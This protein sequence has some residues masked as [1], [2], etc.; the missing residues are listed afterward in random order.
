MEQ[1][2]TAK[3]CQ[4]LWQADGAV[5]Q[6]KV[7]AHVAVALQGIGDQRERTGEHGCPGTTYQQERHNLHILVRTEGNEC[8]AQATEHQTDGIGLLHGGETRNDGCPDY[9]AH[10][11]QGVENARPVACRLIG[12]GLRVGSIP[13]GE[14]DGIDHVGPHIQESGPAEEL[15]QR[16]AP[17]VGGG[18]FQ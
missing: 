14:R 11:L 6:D 8:K 10:G 5:E 16:H 18:V 3:G 2:T 7:C 9:R 4:N 1:E 13:D 12:L 17:V 15:H